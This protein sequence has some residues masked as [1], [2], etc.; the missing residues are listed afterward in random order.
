MTVT[1]PDTVESGRVVTR[2]LKANVRIVGFKMQTTGGKPELG[3][4]SDLQHFVNKVLFQHGYFCLFQHCLWKT[5]H[6]NDTTEWL[7]KGC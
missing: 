1:V 4:E 3:A 6:G 7:L 2:P 5:L